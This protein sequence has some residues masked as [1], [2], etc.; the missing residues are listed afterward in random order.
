MY[1]SFFQYHGVSFVE[2]VLG[3]IILTFSVLKF[4]LIICKKGICICWGSKDYEEGYIL[5]NGKNLELPKIN[6]EFKNLIG[7]TFENDNFCNRFL[8][9]KRI[10]LYMQIKNAIKGNPEI[11][12]SRG[13]E[14][15]KKSRSLFKKLSIR[16][17]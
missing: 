7:G 6:S 9:L 2:S 5:L 4:N 8:E 1:K 17:F 11:S 3:K 15:Y 16:I 13:F 12:I 14:D 10:G